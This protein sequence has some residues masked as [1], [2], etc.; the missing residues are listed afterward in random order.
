M[1]KDKKKEKNDKIK[2]DLLNILDELKDSDLSDA[3][4]EKLEKLTKI[5]SESD[6]FIKKRISKMDILLLLFKLVITFFISM[7]LFSLFY[8]EIILTP[9]LLI[10]AVGGVISVI[11]TLFSLL[12]VRN[13]VRHLFLGSLVYVL[14]IFIICLVNDGFIKVFEDSFIWIFYMILLDVVSDYLFVGILRRIK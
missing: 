9:T 1:K 7:S 11:S 8:A 14:I 12:T 5:V 13:N 6:G 4:K 2:N 10:L 3:D